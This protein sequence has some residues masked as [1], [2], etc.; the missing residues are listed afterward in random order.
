VK[1]LLSKILWFLLG[2]RNMVRLGR[3]LSNEARLD[4]PNVMETNGELMV[5]RVVLQSAK[6]PAIIFDVGAN[7]G[8]W[9]LACLKQDAGSKAQI[10]PFEPSAPTFQRLSDSVKS[11]A[12]VTPVKRALSNHTGRAFLQIAGELAGSN[13]LETSSAATTGTEPVE[14]IT[15]DEFCQTHKIDHIDLL[16]IDA[17]GHDMMVIEGARG[18]LSRRA[19]GVVQFE[20]NWRW[21]EPH[22]TLLDAFKFFAPLGYRIGKIT[23]KGIEFYSSWH[24]ELEMFREANYIACLPE[25]VDRFPTVKWWNE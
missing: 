8:E 25:W 23:P 1:Q 12:T 3:F 22:K 18:L 13:S 11:F 4:V 24:H 19:I 10:F 20:Y 21:V 15:A 16:K 9:T 7:I 5:Q 2:R 14:L 17:E 6:A